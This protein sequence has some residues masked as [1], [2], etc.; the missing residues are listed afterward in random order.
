MD[1]WFLAELTLIWHA[2]P[3]YTNIQWVHYVAES[4]YNGG[5]VVTIAPDYSPSA[6]HADYHLPVRIGTD[7]ALALA[8]CKVIIDA[9]LHDRRFV[10]EQTDLPLLVRTDDGRFSA[11][12]AHRRR[13]LPTRKRRDRW[14]PGGSVLL[15]G[16]ADGCPHAGAARDARPGRGRSGSRR[17]VPG[18]TQGR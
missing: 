13:A 12:G 6:I 7:A 16:Y 15:V 8:M 3:V 11:A 4:R 9:D 17:P 2:N 5:E 14:R 10:Q 18:D 1:D